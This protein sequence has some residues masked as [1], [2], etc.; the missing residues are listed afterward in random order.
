MSGP[1][2]RAGFID[3]PLIGLANRPSRAMVAPTARAAL[4]PML[5][6]PVAVLRM[7]LTRIA[8]STASITSDLQ[9][10]PLVAIG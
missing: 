6:L 2:E 1:R 7:T 10:P 9:S 5:R 4:W 3:A 8:V